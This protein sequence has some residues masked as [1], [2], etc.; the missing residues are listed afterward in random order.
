MPAAC[1][2]HPD[3]PAAFQCAQCGMPIC[4]E[5][6]DRVGEKTVCVRCVQAVRDRLEKQ[7]SAAPAGAYGTPPPSPGSQA[8]GYG[9]PTPMGGGQSYAGN[10]YP[11][12]R[13]TPAPVQWLVGIGL[14][15][16]IGIVGAIAVEKFEFSTHLSLSL[17]YV[18]VGYGVGWGVLK[19][20]GQGGTPVAVTGAVIYLL[21]VI[22]APVAEAQD[23]L[24]KVRAEDPS[25]A[26]VTAVQ[27]LPAVL[28][29]EG[30]MF[31]IFV[32]F[33]AYGCFRYVMRRS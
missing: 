7:M 28:S 15:L 5:D 29:H 25:A 33:G 8:G 13:G 9:G 6:T 3:R 11:S 1:F 21:S 2:Y 16:V 26:G 10:A 31:W 18:L 12:T 17:L 24:N 23:Y 20:V 30:F 4:Q 32:A 27:I 19:G 14:G 22:A